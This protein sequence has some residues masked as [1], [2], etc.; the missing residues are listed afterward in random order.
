MRA[1]PRLTWKFPNRGGQ[2]SGGP[3]VKDDCRL[4]S[5][6]GSPCLWKLPFVVGL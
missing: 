4:G 5:I 6:L 1:E 3:H 2:L